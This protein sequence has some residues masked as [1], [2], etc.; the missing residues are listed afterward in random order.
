VVVTLTTC[1]YGDIY[2]KTDAGKMLFV[3]VIIFGLY[4]ITS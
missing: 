2:P 1:G 3:L 4:S